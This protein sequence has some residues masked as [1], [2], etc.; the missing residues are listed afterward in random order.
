MI[1]KLR[2]K[3]VGIMMTIITIF[4]VLIL[5][6]LY[7]S[8]Q[9]NYR[10]QSMDTLHSAIKEVKEASSGNPPPPAPRS[11]PPLPAREASPILVADVKTDGSISIIKNRIFSVDNSE[12][13]ML[14]ALA[15]QQEGSS[16]TMKD[17]HLRFLCDKKRPGGAVRYAFVDIY[18]EQ[19][20]LYWQA[21]HSV[22]IGGCA[23][24][25]FFIF[26]VLLSKWAVKP[27][28]TAWK[29][30]QQFVADA[31]HELKTPLTVILSNANM[32]VHT[33]DIPSGRNNQRI[34]HIQAEAIRMKQ[35]LESLLTLAKSDS[36]EQPW[37]HSR[38]SLSFI[39][40]SSILSFEPVAFDMGKYI[41]S[42]VEDS[43]E[44][45]GD[46]KK[47]RQLTD[48]LLDNACKYSAEGST[49][50]VSLSRSGPKEALL[51]VPN[52]GCPLSEDEMQHIFLRFYRADPSRGGI[53]GYGLGL[54]I[55][56]SIASEHGARIDVTTDGV[57]RN[58]FSVRIPVC[59]PNTLG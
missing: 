35:L 9:L 15:D 1:R 34:E 28:E 42:Q 17:R 53:P 24:G 46:E 41:S 57:K 36:G 39:V 13:E 33:P 18:A 20:S 30:Q 51:S 59:L 14:I 23:F 40:N 47:L 21:I 8:A 7:Y 3:F 22:I 54:S 6:T 12:L 19:N 56:R 48:I 58:Y 27:V 29:R 49:I 31:S 43:I 50:L 38:I 10:S 11:G 4:L 32:L 16:G 52:E 45:D 26:S 44:M 5:T 2:W 55:A 25:A 37:E